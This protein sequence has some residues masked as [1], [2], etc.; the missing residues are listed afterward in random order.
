[1]HHFY[2][3]LEQQEAEPMG[4]NNKERPINQLS[5]MSFLCLPV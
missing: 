2:G 3:V 4:R 1:M 5:V